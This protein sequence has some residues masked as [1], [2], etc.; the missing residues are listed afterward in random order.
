MNS[1]I[2][3]ISAPAEGEPGGTCALRP[4]SASSPSLG[5]TLPNSITAMPNVSGWELA[6]DYSKNLFIATKLY[7]L[8][9]CNFNEMRWAE[10]SASVEPPLG[11]PKNWRI[12][13]PIANDFFTCKPPLRTLFNTK[14]ILQS[15]YGQKPTPDYDYFRLLA[16][17][18]NRISHL[19]IYPDLEDMSEEEEMH[20]DEDVV[21][22]THFLLDKLPPPTWLPRTELL[23]DGSLSLNWRNSL[24]VGG[25]RLLGIG[26]VDCYL[27]HQ[28]RILIEESIPLKEDKIDQF[29]KMMLRSYSGDEPLYE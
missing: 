14:I 6:D 4:P 25:F 1:F 26:Q 29:I 7:G 8:R 22:E 17:L 13:I 19:T 5:I 11:V 23:A 16:D 9:Q 2:P 28:D 27:R 10:A 18:K 21:R 15:W 3:W 24:M 20:P 12:T